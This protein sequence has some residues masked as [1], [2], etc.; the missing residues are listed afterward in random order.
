MTSEMGCMVTSITVYTRR[1]I[2]ATHRCRQL[3]T[4]NLTMSKY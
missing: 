3:V 4:Q 2:G 1:Q